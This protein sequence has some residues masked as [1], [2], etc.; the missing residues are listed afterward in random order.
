[1]PAFKIN[2]WLNLMMFT[3]LASMLDISMRWM[4]QSRPQVME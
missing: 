4:L 1:M 2:A 3:M